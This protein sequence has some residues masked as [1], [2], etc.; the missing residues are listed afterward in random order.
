MESA[1]NHISINEAGAGADNSDQ[2]ED[3]KWLFVTNIC[4]STYNNVTYI[5]VI[6]DIYF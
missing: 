5:H 2:Y 6:F 3:D 4:I 1:F